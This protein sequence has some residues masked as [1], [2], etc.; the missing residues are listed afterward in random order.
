MPATESFNNQIY[1]ENS[2]AKKTES[3][4]TFTAEV[5]E[6]FSCE[7]CSKRKKKR[8]EK[9]YQTM[10]NRLK[11]I[12][13]QVRG[14]ER[15]LEEDTYCVDILTQVMAVNSALNSFSK[16]LLASHIRS[17][18]TNDIREGKEESVDELIAIFQKLM[19]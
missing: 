19:K 12:E 6:E 1:Q 13:G 18:V 4:N 17:C 15:L 8:G 2:M 9:E 10:M 11:R 16:E 3:S 7:N 5:H 14:L